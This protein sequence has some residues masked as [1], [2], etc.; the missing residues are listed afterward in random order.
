M[1]EDFLAEYV[2]DTTAH[3]IIQTV[4]LSILL[5]LTVAVRRMVPTITE[6]IFNRLHQIAKYTPISEELLREKAI[7]ALLPPFRLLTTILGVWMAL[8]VSGVAD[9]LQPL[10]NTTFLSLV[11]LAIHWGIF[12]IVEQYHIDLL[13]RWKLDQDSWAF[14]NRAA[15]FAGESLQLGASLRQRFRSNEENDFGKIASTDCIAGHGFR[16]SFAA[17]GL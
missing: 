17:S 1:I 7:E 11:L 12:R 13:V 8:L 5:A 10:L 2:G 3:T 14:V 4:V 16:S 9:S 15:A 6:Y